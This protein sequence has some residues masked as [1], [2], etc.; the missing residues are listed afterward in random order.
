MVVGNDGNFRRYID[1]T[2]AV[3]SGIA[4]ILLTR[5]GERIY[6]PEFGSRLYQLI[7]EPNGPELW[8]IIQTEVFSAIDRWEPRI[9]NLRVQVEPDPTNQNLLRVGISYTIISNNVPENFVFPL[10]LQPAGE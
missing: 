10:F 6:N 2:R 5:P 3:Q 7:H 9:T 1:N 4:I 8:R